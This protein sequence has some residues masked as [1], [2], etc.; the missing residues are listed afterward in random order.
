MSPRLQGM[1][2]PKPPSLSPSVFISLLRRAARLGN[3]LCPLLLPPIHF[4]NISKGPVFSTRCSERRGVGSAAA[5]KPPALGIRGSSGKRQGCKRTWTAA[6]PLPRRLCLC[7]GAAIP[8]L[9][10]G[11]EVTP[12]VSTEFKRERGGSGSQQGARQPKNSQ[13]GRAVRSAG[14]R[15]FPL[16]PSM[17]APGESG[18]DRECSP[19]ACAKVLRPA[20]GDRCSQGGQ[21]E[22]S[23]K[24]NSS[25]KNIGFKCC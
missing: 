15:R 11:R 18:G 21:R 5:F 24:I 17:G 2:S 8:R 3:Q 9:G 22:R 10:E 7:A 19:Q 23:G 20:D 4:L 16:A 1:L 14:T 13:A 12:C 25:R 6:L